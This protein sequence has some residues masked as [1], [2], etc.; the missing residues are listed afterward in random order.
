MHRT[1][2]K[3]FKGPIPDGKVIMHLCNN[4]RCI[5]PKHLEVGDTTENIRMAIVDGLHPASFHYQKIY[6]AEPKVNYQLRVRPKVNF[7]RRF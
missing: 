3:A 7:L 4:K 1:S 6:Q 5:N 2:Y